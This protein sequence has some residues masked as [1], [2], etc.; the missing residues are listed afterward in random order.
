MVSLETIYAHFKSCGYQFTTDSRKIIPGGLF[1]ALKGERFNGNAFA[2][3]ALE[4]GASF[5]IVDEEAYMPKQGDERYLLVEDGLKTLQ[6]LAT[7]HR[8]S[9]KIPVIGVCGSNGKTTTKEL[10]VAVLSQKYEV[11]FTEGNLNN[12]IG[13][14]LTLLR[15]RNSH[16]V[17]VIEMGANHLQEIA[18]LCEIACPTHGLI[19]SIG[20]DHLEGY[21]SVENVAKSNEELFGFLKKTGGFAWI[22]ADDPYVYEMNAKGLEHSYYGKKQYFTGKILSQNLMGM[23]ISLQKP[24][25]LHPLMVD[26]QLAGQHNFQNIL[27]A[28][29]VGVTLGIEPEEIIAAFQGFQPKNNRS[30]ILQQ[31]GRT[32]LLDAYNAN[33]SSVE[34]TLK[35]FLAVPGNGKAVILGDMFELG[36]FADQEHHRILEKALEQDGVKVIACGPCFDKA[37]G[38]FAHKN[39]RTFKD[40]DSLQ[41]ENLEVQNFIKACDQILIKGS[42]GMAMERIM[43][44]LA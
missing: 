8:N 43:E 22:N 39:L 38:L 41:Q 7:L 34:A 13:V 32:I 26:T 42:R 23:T 27:A 28:W 33:P 20:L 2:S 37:G 17:A 3:K 14:P 29:A 40:F 30:Q 25:L 44:V 21:G 12:H 16:E 18:D 10:I 6:H 24:G 9:F 4:E 11:L 1:L 36:A 5:V 15:L 35:F 19:T 31:N